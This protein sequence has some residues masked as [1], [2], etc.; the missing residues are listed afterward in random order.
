MAKSITKSK[1]SLARIQKERDVL[2]R[3]IL[4]DRE[5]AIG[6]VSV[7][8]GTCGKS[9]CH[10]ASGDTGHPQTIFLYKGSDGRRRCKHVRQEDSHKLLAAHKSYADFRNNLRELRHLS[11]QEQAVGVAIRKERALIY[12]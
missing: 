11:Q 4:A 8:E 10:C 9:T 7:V 12:K 1:K 3:L 2:H 6:S 5:L